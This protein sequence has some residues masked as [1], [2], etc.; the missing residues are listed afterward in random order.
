MTSGSTLWTA[1][2]AARATGGRSVGDWQASGV[3]IDTRTLKPGDLF[4][5][6]KGPSFDGHEFA[7]EGLA[8]GA[9]AII[10]SDVPPAIDTAAPMLIVPDTLRAL[11]DL[12]RAARARC[13]A[14]I[15]GVTGSVGKTSVKEALKLVLSAQAPTTAN[16]GS[17]NNHWGL[18]LSLARMPESVS[19]GV[20][21]MGMNHTGEI[22]PLS[23]MARPHVV[24][25]TAVEAVHKAHFKNVEAIA[26]AKA[27][28]FNGVV[29]GGVAV[30]NRDNYQFARL[31][32]AAGDHGIGRI[33]D[34]GRHA[35]AAVRAIEVD[36]T[37]T[38]SM[39]R[40]LVDGDELDY[41]L[42]VPGEHWV[43]NSLC[44][45]AAVTA[46]GGDIPTAAASLAEVIAPKGRG[47]RSDIAIEG[48]TFGL[49]DDSYNAS[50]V[51]MAAAFEVL[52]RA[53]IG[54]RGRRIAV[55]GDMLEL[56]DESPLLHAAL[57]QPLRRNGID[58]VF[59]AGSAMARLFEVLPTDMRG[60]HAADSTA[61]K[62]LVTAAVRPGDVVTVK[63]SAGS[64]MG[65]VVEALRGL[66]LGQGGAARAGNGE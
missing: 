11:E 48:G 5:A 31:A 42:N 21:E 53:R 6:L 64:R 38:G 26:D 62:P 27:E 39:V 29:D 19:F 40:A 9:A 60:G 33:I 45:L 37:T 66:D 24:A 1:G 43:I 59:T 22:E 49:I 4:V 63:G 23:L 65:V 51:S 50:P 47:R 55:V 18:P 34:F 44:V 30:L 52:A 14:R 8:N 2:E 41:R 17:L 35:E 36:I 25:I 12:G 28:I 16:D 46:V 32:R 15:I 3:S 58:L 10:V 56:G 54:E 13:N 20:F 7:A 57:L 61:L